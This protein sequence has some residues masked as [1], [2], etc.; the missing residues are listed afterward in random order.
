MTTFAETEIQF[1][2]GQKNVEELPPNLLANGWIPKQKGTEG[3]PLVANWLNWLFREVFRKINRDRLS[4]GLG[5]NT[6]STDES[7]ITIYAVVKTDPTK[8]I[9][10]VGYK[11][12]NGVP[13]MT[14]IG[15]NTLT[16]GTV[17]ATNTPINGAAS[18][19]IAVRVTTS[20]IV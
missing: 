14:V 17:T 15:N 18:G 9:H 8:Y 2:D 5:V 10:A 12:G 6:I 1:Q 19:T 4:D 7:L 20:E 16:L 3:Q 13:I 11:T